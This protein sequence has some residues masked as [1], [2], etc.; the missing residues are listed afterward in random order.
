MNTRRIQRGKVLYS[1]S[2]AVNGN[3]IEVSDEITEYLGYTGYEDENVVCRF[4]FARR[5]F[6]GATRIFFKE[7]PET[8]KHYAGFSS[9]PG[10]RNDLWLCKQ[11][12]HSILRVGRRTKQ[13]SL[14]VKKG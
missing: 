5:P 1:T 9:N 13:F 4:R 3:E 8:H 12:C 14:W 11:K 6:A 10:R 2:I 7:C